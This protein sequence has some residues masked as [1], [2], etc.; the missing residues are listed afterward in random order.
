[1]RQEELEQN[2]IREEID[3]VKNLNRI[4]KLTKN[5]RVKQI[6]KD[7][8]EYVKKIVKYRYD[9]LVMHRD[10]RIKIN[11]DKKDV[12]RWRKE[13]HFNAIVTCA[14]VIIAL[15]VVFDMVYKLAEIDVSLKDLGVI[16]MSIVTS[17]KVIADIILIALFV[18]FY[19]V[20][21]SIRKKG[22]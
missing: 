1:M 2:G 20:W 9:I 8:V 19:Y 22:K 13:N 18:L 14:T 4:D 7:S 17:Y 6:V 21:K 16:D 11:E 15:G 5:R 12:D 10:E 3:L